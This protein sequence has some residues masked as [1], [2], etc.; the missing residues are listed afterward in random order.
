MTRLPES[1]SP[2]PQN[3]ADHD[4]SGHESQ[5]LETWIA[6]FITLMSYAVKWRKPGLMW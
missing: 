3:I 2:H 6:F 1:S 5:R 4:A